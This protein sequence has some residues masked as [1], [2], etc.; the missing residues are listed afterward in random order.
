MEEKINLQNEIKNY[1]FF[2]PEDYDYV[3]GMASNAAYTYLYA[4]LDEVRADLCTALQSITKGTKT[5]SESLGA[6][7]GKVDNALLNIE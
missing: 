6:V 3:M 4:E 1:Y 5:V 7:S 2:H